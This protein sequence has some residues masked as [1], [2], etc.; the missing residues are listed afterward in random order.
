MEPDEQTDFA[1]LL[2]RH[3]AAAG[4]SQEALAERAG[5][6][7][8]GI[9]DLERG[10]RAFPYAE[11]LRRLADA[12][13]LDAVDRATFL[14]AGHRPSSS[15]RPTPSRAEPSTAI[16]SVG[17]LTNLPAPRTRLIG[18]EADLEAVRDRVLHAQGRPVTLVGAGG[19]GKTALA[20]EVARGLLRDFHDGVWLV[21]LAQCTSAA[22]WSATS[23]RPTALRGVLEHPGARAY[24]AAEH[25]RQARF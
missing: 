3:R 19:S 21:E 5:L 12:L 14:A 6:S 1:A 17:R 8:R 16:S 24:G 7:R 13:A 20:F 2:R 11:T 23:C 10:A 18:R 22:P 4:L 25:T 15:T 9:A